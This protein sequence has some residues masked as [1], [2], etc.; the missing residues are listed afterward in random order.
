MSDAPPATELRVGLEGHFERAV[1]FEY[2][3]AAFDPKLPTI[4]S[5][6]AMIAFMEAATSIAV[7]PAL[8][9][10]TITVGTR[11]EVDHIKATG[12]GSLVRAT[13]R[14]AAINGRFL[15]FDVEARAAGEVLGRGQIT[16]A[17]VDLDRMHQRA[18][19]TAAPSR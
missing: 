12:I 3:T 10:G 7:Q 4:F 5:T 9:P 14:L 18:A 13:A 19:A 8:A 11:I 15:I 2:T 6:P 1:A 17:I 16:R